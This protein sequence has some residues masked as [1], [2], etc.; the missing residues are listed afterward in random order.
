MQDPPRKEVKSAIE[1]CRKAGIRV[2]VITGDNKTTAEAICREVGIFEADEDLKERSLAGREFMRLSQTDRRS[3]LLGACKGNFVVSRAEPIHKQEIVRVLQSGG[4]VVAMTGDG[5]NDAPALKLADIGVAMGITGT[6]VNF[7]P[8]V[9]PL[10]Y[11]QTTPIQ[12]SAQQIMRVNCL[13]NAY[14][15]RRLIKPQGLVC[16]L[17]LD[18][19]FYNLTCQLPLQV[20]KEACDMVLADDN[21]ATIVLA[22]KE[23]RS[24]YDNMKAFIRYLI[25]S[26]IGEVVS[27]FLTALLGF[28]QGLIPVQLLWVN[29]V[30]DGAPATALGFNEPDKGI[31]ERAPRP[32]DESLVG[33]WTFFRFLTIGTYVGVATTGIFVL[34]YLNNTTF[35]GIDMSRDGHTAVTLSQLSHWGECPLWPDF[36]VTPY[37]AGSHTYDFANACDYF[38]A[39]KVKASTLS[40]SA[41]VV[42]EMLNAL[43][44]LSENNSLLTVPP[45][46]NKWLLVAIGV[47]MGL[48]FTILYNP[49]L[50]DVFGVVPLSVEEWLVVLVVSLPIIPIDEALKMWG[51]S[52]RKSGSL[53]P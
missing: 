42:M 38:A 35:L 9:K 3:L 5:V 52:H 8:G 50:A 27:I 40:M 13:R 24:I 36:S 23:G 18:R 29:L 25:S 2:V 37:T 11:S 26:N 41:L 17:R 48:H 47:S 34:W 20:A 1:N 19:H 16:N 28:P 21:F 4:E 10:W 32:S 44:A 43:N 51:R 53:K 12:N 39:G 46:A 45:W 33:N 22:V 49:W 6:E 30:T 7:V 31:M 14:N 15:I